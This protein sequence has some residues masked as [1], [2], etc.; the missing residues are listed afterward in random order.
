[1]S[2]YFVSIWILCVLH[3]SNSKSNKT[4]IL[5]LF[6]EKGVVERWDSSTI[7]ISNRFKKYQ[8]L[9]NLNF[10]TTRGNE[11]RRFGD[12]SIS[13]QSRIVKASREWKIIFWPFSSNVVVVSLEH[14]REIMTFYVM[15]VLIFQSSSTH[16]LFISVKNVLAHT[17]RREEWRAS[18]KIKKS[19]TWAL[20]S[21]ARNRVRL[22]PH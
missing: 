6:G 3:V 12:E 2:K 16:L 9:I 18:M 15:H 5:R 17:I 10:Y 8:A 20:E 19:A 14:Q 1:M 11:E 22:L 4:H 21:R 7:I 13:S